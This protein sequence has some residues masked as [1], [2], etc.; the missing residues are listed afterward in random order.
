[1]ANHTNHKPPSKKSAITVRGT[2]PV[3]FPAELEERTVKKR[4]DAE[5]RA[6]AMARKYQKEHPYLFGKEPYLCPELKRPPGIPDS[7]F[8]AFELPS[9]EFGVLRWPDGFVEPDNHCPQPHA[10]SPNAR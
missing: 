6:R 4:S 5:S 7:R 8:R 10:E 2:S 9:R 3:L 1:M